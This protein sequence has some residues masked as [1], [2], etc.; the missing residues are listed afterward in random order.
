MEIKNS[1]WFETKVSYMK[2]NDKGAI[3]RTSEMFVVDA[4]SFTEAEAN[5][6]EYISD[7]SM[8]EAQI[9]TIKRADFSEILFSDNEQDDK[10]YKVKL[11]YITLNERTNEGTRS[12]VN[13]LV[14]ANNID[15]ANAYIKEMMRDSMADYVIE[16]LHETKIMDVIEHE[17]E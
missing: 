8:N 7:Y 13:Y 5:I 16:V 12:Y 15:K 2:T 11:A 1:T 9:A 4:L 3:K 14:Q 17:E 10:W 6:S